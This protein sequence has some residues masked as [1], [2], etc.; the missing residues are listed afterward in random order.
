MAPEALRLQV[1]AAVPSKGKFSPMAWV[2]L[3]QAGVFPS[4]HFQ[5]SFLQFVGWALCV[6]HSHVSTESHP[7]SSGL[8]DEGWSMKGSGYNVCGTRIT[9]ISGSLDAFG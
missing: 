6:V 9:S 5:F 4:K 7:Q 1:C 2:W 3:P 8:R